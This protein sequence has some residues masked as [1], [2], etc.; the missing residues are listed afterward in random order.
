MN[1]V[2]VNVN[3][4]STQNPHA[5]IM[6][7]HFDLNQETEIMSLYT[8]DDWL[9]CL[10]FSV[11]HAHANTFF[12][13]QDSGRLSAAGTASCGSGPLPWTW[14]WT[15]HKDSPLLSDMHACNLSSG[16]AH[17]GLSVIKTIITDC[18]QCTCSTAF[19]RAHARFSSVRNTTETN[20]TPQ[21]RI[22]VAIPYN[23]LKPT[24]C[25]ISPPLKPEAWTTG[26]HC[27]SLN[28]NY[29]YIQ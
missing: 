1:F 18:L 16:M 12:V 2:K 13:H 21:D 19:V 5:L 6:M 24:V 8:A 10:T 25:K 14:T 29:I 28:R 20:F 26:L 9:L 7:W 4:H 3:T 17:P 22:S 11:G 23:D 27:I 15:C